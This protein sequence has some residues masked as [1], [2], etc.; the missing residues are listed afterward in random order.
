MVGCRVPTACGEVKWDASR[1]RRRRTQYAALSVTVDPNVAAP[2]HRAPPDPTSLCPT[3]APASLMSA[4]N[5]DGPPR[6][7]STVTM[8]P[9]MVACG[10][11]THGRGV[12]GSRSRSLHASAP[13][14]SRSATG[15][16]RKIAGRH[17]FSVRHSTG[18]SLGPS[19]GEARHTVTRFE[20][21]APDGRPHLPYIG[22]EKSAGA[23]PRRCP[24]RY[25]RCE[26]ISAGA[27]RDITRPLA[28]VR[29]RRRDPCGQFA[30]TRVAA[31]LP[32]VRR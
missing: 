12:L 9:T 28:R 14:R 3:T 6:V 10:L 15:A 16:A 23:G 7:G 26:W 25:G 11:T 24:R 5:V 13:V 1:R 22:P 31:G 18:T 29:G 21:T 30:P 2:D 32:P 27:F 17:G 8:A 19:D 4:A 20:L